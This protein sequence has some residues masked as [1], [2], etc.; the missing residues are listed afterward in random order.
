MRVNKRVSRG[1][2]NRGSK[3]QTQKQQTIATEG[4][5]AAAVSSG[6]IGVKFNRQ[7]GF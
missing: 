6:S 3:R 7:S 5:V 2:E 1:D 4:W